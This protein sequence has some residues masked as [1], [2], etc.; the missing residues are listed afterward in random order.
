MKINTKPQAAKK[1]VGELASERPKTNIER[2]NAWLKKNGKPDD[3][4]IYLNDYD[5]PLDAA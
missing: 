1:P 5:Y 3:A 4:H 2:I